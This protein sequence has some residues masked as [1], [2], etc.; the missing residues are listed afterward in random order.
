MASS[1]PMGLGELINGATK[2]IMLHVNICPEDS[3]MG[4]TRQ[5]G[6]LW[7]LKG[8]QLQ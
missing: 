6:A 4:K 2:G 7:S 1:S 3:V 5:P 8:L